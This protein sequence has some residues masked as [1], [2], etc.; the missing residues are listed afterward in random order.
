M[1]NRNGEP[2]RWWESVLTL[3]PLFFI[4]VTLIGG[5]SLVRRAQQAGFSGREVVGEAGLDYIVASGVALLAPWVIGVGAL[6]ALGWCIERLINLPAAKT[7]DLLSWLAAGLCAVTIVGGGAVWAR[8]GKPDEARV[9][10]DTQG[11]FCAHVVL[12][13]PSMVYAQVKT[14]GARSPKGALAATSFPIGKVIALSAA[15]KVACG[16]VDLD[17]LGG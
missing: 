2:H 9:V 6:I 15:P 14:R 13:T 17:K 8:P 1:K 4:A 5:L 10:L 7:H 12:R 3:T 16:P 11:R